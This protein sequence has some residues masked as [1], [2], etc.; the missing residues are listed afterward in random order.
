MDQRGRKVLV[1]DDVLEMESL[2]KLS[3]SRERNDQVTFVDSGPK[4][5]TAAHQD[6]PHL[7]ILDLAMPDVDGYQVLREF[8]NTP[9]LQTVPVL[10]ISALDS[11][12]V[13]RRVQQFGIQG[14]LGKPFGLQEL[15]AARDAMLRG[16]T[17]YRF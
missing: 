16:E 9:V 12:D 4:G 10:V 14:Y 13:R 15:L 17:F 8:K 1:I 6:R 5:L 3:L 11:Y 7:I 2:L